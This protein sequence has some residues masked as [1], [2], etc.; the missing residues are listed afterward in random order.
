[1]IKYVDSE[2]DNLKKSLEKEMADD[3]ADETKIYPS[4]ITLF[5]EIKNKFDTCS[6][7]NTGKILADLSQKFL[8]VLAFYNEKIALRLPKNERLGK[9]LDGEEISIAFV[10]NTAEYCRSTICEMETTI[11]AKLETLY[12]IECYKEKGLFAEY[13]LF[14]LAV[15][16]VQ[17]LLQV[18]ELK[19]DPHFSN[20][21]K[22]DWNLEAV[23]DKSDYIMKI[24]EIL[25][26]FCKN[27]QSVLN[28]DY[29]LN[30]FNKLAEY[31]L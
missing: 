15:K 18:F 20:M 31:S 3:V 16:G 11:R 30:F 24:S 7:F 17:T 5:T 2:E 28:E 1:M 27:I 19:I 12:D 23:G 29:L 26:K 9:V 8:V 21:T 22:L 6:S 25:V 4:S 14:R 13:S 10:I